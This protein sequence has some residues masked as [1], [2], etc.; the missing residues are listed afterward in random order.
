VGTIRAP[1]LFRA[2]K[3]TDLGGG[4]RRPPPPDKNALGEAEARPRRV[5]LDPQGA[6]EHNPKTVDLDLPRDSL[7]V[8][9][10]LSG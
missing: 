4:T 3:S 6:R 9:T 2:A 7:V 10:G 1:S 8:L 5:H